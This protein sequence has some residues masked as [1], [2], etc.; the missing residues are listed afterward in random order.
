[1]NIADQI[2]LKLQLK[3]NSEVEYKSA[4][5]GFPKAEFWRSFSALANTNGG[6]I[7]LGVK[8]KNHKFTPD[9]LSEELVA[10]YRKQF[11]D[12][13]HNKSCVNIPLLVESDIE[14]I[15]TEGG[16][17]LLAFRI[18]RAQYDLRPIH[19]TL[20]PFGH[21]YK[22]RDEGD[23]LCSDDEIKQMY[24]D[25]NNM[26]ASADSRILRG[27]SID[28]I[29]I[30]TLHQYRRAYDI[31]HENHPWTELDDKKFLEIIGAYRKDRA[32]STEGFTV[33]GML[34]F[35]KT[36]SITDPE[37][38]Q[39]FFPD[40][41]EHL[42]DDLQVRWTNRIYPDGTWEA[43]LYQ[44]FTRVLP[45]LQHALPVPFSLD[46]NQMR[47]NT[48]TAHVA[49]REA[50]ANSLI[51]A[52][53]TVRGNIVIDR[54]FDRIVLSNPG[55]MLISME[56]YYEG[57]HSVCRNPV[58]QKMFVFLGIGEKGG[59]G[60][61]VIAKGWKD[62]GWSI[63]TV[64]EKSNPDRI[65]TCLKLEGNINGTTG[66]SSVTTEIPADTTETTTETP[67]ATTETSADTTE[68]TTETPSATTETSA[69]TTETTTETPSATT[70]TSADTT[71]TILKIISNNPKVTAKEIASV[72]GITEDGVAYHIKKLKQRGRI[73]RI[74]GSRNGGEW[75]V[76]E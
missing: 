71:E 30:P 50:F 36:N 73:F 24:S 12:D 21:T 49:L 35:G 20:T 60:A 69:D 15:K 29:D 25:A 3:E 14:E 45:L 28:D 70:E 52:A 39:E 65:E 16:Q 62:N 40:Y 33:A 64:E 1:M 10:K 68:T 51:H 31:K 13:A 72:C 54:Y 17:Y 55:T 5:G 22:R 9:G 56:E 75:K 48:T 7:V 66:T 46:N 2:R 58:I 38:C 76:V 63:P 42:S 8:E 37:C 26:R 74:G 57:G 32:T 44:F 4:A 43:N 53:Y 59:T 23:Y 61:D 34:M 41:R 27:Y 18:P 47:N 11:W 6:T 67:S 19:L